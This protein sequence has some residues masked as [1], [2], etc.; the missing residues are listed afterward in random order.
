MMPLPVGSLCEGSH[1]ESG[2]CEGSLCESGLCEGSL[3]ESGLCEGVSVRVLFSLHT[4]GSLSR[5]P[6]NRDP[7]DRDNPGLREPLWTK[8]PPDTD[9]PGQ[10]RPLTETPLDRDPP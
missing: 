8:R 10:R 7:L 6:P 2:L 4:E 9:P 5:E 3:C 1:C